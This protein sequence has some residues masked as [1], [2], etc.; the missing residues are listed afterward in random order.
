MLAKLSMN[1]QLEKK[2]TMTFFT[3]CGGKLLFWE[4]ALNIYKQG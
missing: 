1:V 4:D 3:L 2:I